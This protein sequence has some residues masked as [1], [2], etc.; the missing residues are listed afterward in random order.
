MSPS[1]G[2][3]ERILCWMGFRPGGSIGR[4]LAIKPK[5]SEFEYQSGQNFAEIKRFLLMRI[6]NK[7]ADCVKNN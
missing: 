3:F 4:A 2:C 6:I 1:N 5:G 7:A